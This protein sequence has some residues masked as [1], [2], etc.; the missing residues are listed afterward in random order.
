MTSFKKIHR[1]RFHG[2]QQKHGFD[3]GC[4]VYCIHRGRLL[5]G[6]W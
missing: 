2:I 4:R 6:I 3:G 5:R 1:D